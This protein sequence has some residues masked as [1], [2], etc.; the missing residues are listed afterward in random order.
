MLIFFCPFLKGVLSRA[1]CYPSDLFSQNFCILGSGWGTV[2]R[3]TDYIK[4]KLN[5]VLLS[6]ISNV[7]HNCESWF[8][9]MCEYT[10]QVRYLNHLIQS[11]L[12]LPENARIWACY[13][14]HEKPWMCPTTEPQSF[15][16]TEQVILFLELV[17]KLQNPLA[18]GLSLVGKGLPSSHMWMQLIL[19]IK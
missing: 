10:F 13:L 11:F 5:K 14:F 19:Q 2:I 8:S 9:A 17:E 6:M 16:W 12:A 15:P 1:H 18:E 4:S 7:R 3:F